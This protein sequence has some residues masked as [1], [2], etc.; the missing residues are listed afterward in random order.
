MTFK[1]SITFLNRACFCI[2]VSYKAKLKFALVKVLLPIWSYRDN[3][4]VITKNELCEANLSEKTE[5]NLN[6]WTTS[7]L[8][9]LWWLLPSSA[10]FNR[11]NII[12]SFLPVELEFSGMTRPDP[13]FFF[14]WFCV[15]QYSMFCFVLCTVVCI[16]FYFSFVY[17]HGVVCLNYNFIDHLVFPPYFWFLLIF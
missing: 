9:E 8:T 4:I 16:F 6:N 3:H 11:I 7:L 5:S 12:G 1:Q 10:Y 13:F 14:C 15:V 2:Y 17:G